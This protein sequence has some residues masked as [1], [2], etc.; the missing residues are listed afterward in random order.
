MF[1][2]RHALQI[3][4]T[5][6]DCTKPSLAAEGIEQTARVSRAIHALKIPIGRVLSSYP[7]RNQ[8]T[9]R[10]LAL[11]AVELT[12]DLNPMGLPDGAN[13]TAARM[14]RLAELPAKGTNTL[15]ISHVHGSKN[16][17][18]W[19]HLEI[20]EI[21]VYRPDGKPVLAPPAPVARI[22]VEAWEALMALDAAKP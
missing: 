1:Y 21:I 13:P 15:L 6:E 22:R 19:M 20:A 12:A 16:K 3:P 8:E 10:R 2:M 14:K 5:D 18:E 4:P 9:A 7:C 17:A 11:G